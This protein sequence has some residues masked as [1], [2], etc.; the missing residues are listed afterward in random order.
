VQKKQLF[1]TLRKSWKPGLLIGIANSIAVI[2]FFNAVKML[3]PQ[4]AGF[5]SRT[6]VLFIILVGMV[7]L[8]EKL[9]FLEGSGMIVAITGAA[10]LT[11]S[12]GSYTLTGSILI[13]TSTLFV[14]VQV[15]LI[16]KFISSANPAIMIAFRCFFTLLILAAYLFSTQ[17]FNPLPLHLL[18]WVIISS[19]ISAVFGWMLFFA[20]LHHIKAAKAGIM[21]N[22]DPFFV[23][24]YALLFFNTLP[25]SLQLIGGV[26][27]VTGAALTLA[28]KRNSRRS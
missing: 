12:G 3:E 1:S 23:V 7:L 18:P 25:T 16:K 5:L 13:I 9:N 14:A 19:S 21:R 20:S 15:Y 10:I 17:E 6:E 28:A 2:L 11:F 22:M 4:V 8:R 24:I 26:L 27:I